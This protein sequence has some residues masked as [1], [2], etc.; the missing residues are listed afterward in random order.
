MTVTVR[1][2]AEG[3]EDAF[4]T[5]YRDCLDHYDVGPSRPEVEA[6][7][8][9]DLL[10]PRGM[11]ALIAWNGAR[12]LGFATWARVY[13][14]GNG[15]AVYLKELYVAAEARGFGA[16]KALMRALANIAIDTG[17]VRL[18]WGSF[19]PEALKFYDALG[20]PRMEKAHFSVPA[21]DLPTFSR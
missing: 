8:L 3:E 18:E 6:E 11:S 14:A 7:I 5:L 21:A 1:V 9:A 17:A 15:V 19:Q 10:A 13:P 4:L 20:A 16:G 12:P 2:L